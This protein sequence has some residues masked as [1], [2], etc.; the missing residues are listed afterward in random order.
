MKLLVLCMAA[1]ALCGCAYPTSSVVQGAEAG[2]LRF[3]D[4]PIGAQITID[5]R[6]VGARTDDRPVVYDVPPGRHVIQAGSGGNL[7]FQ[8]EYDV[9]AGS[10]LDIRTAN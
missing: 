1:M 2:H 9:G 3:A 8:R 10:T 5:G 7:L 6:A 4:S